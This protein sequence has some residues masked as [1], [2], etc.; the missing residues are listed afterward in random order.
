LG[1]WC[2]VPKNSTIRPHATEAL[3]GVQADHHL[4]ST[5]CRYEHPVTN[6]T[7][8]RACDLAARTATRL[9]RHSS[10]SLGCSPNGCSWKGVGCVNES[11]SAPRR[12]PLNCPREFMTEPQFSRG[13][14]VLLASFGICTGGMEVCKVR[15][16][17]ASE[18]RRSW[19]KLNSP[20]P[21]AKRAA[22][23]SLQHG[24][25]YITTIV[26]HCRGLR[27]SARRASCSGV[28]RGQD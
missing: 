25:D 22:A 28:E 8:S 3:A 23:F 26:S 21:E 11:S 16:N 7:G 12:Q 15:V 2:I 5:C 14:F 20:L 1:S 19:Y 10:S 27:P 13:Y 24:S 9:S 4:F 18:P 6:P 17:L